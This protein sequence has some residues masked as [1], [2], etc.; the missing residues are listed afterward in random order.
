MRITK[1]VFTDLG[2]WMV[3]FGLMIGIVFP[4]FVTILGV[5]SS[6]A[7]KPGFFAASL[8]AGALAGV[9]N[10]LL[11]RFIVATRIK[12]LSSGMRQVEEHLQDLNNQGNLD[13]CTYESCSLPVDSEDELGDSA[14]AFNR[15][16]ETLAYSLETQEALQTFSEMLASTLELETLAEKSLEMFLDHTGS[17]GGLVL[18]E[19]AGQLEVAASRGIKDPE[20]ISESDYVKIAFQK[21]E[22]QKVQ[23]PNEIKIEGV[24]AEFRPREI[25][26]FPAKYKEVPLGVVVLGKTEA[27][28]A[29]EQIRLELFRQGFGLALNNVLAHDRLQRLAALDPLTGVYNRRFGLRRLHE[30]FERAVRSSSHLGLL[31]M[32][33]DHFKNVNDVYGHQMGDRL[34]KSSATII[35][36]VLREGDVLIRYGGEEFL[37]VLPAASNDDLM[38]IGERMRRGIEASALMDGEQ[39][40]RV[41]ISVGGAAYPNQN[42][43]KKDA[44][45]QLADE[46]LYKAKQTGR[47]QVIISE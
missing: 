29:G 1:K 39:T 31:M 33:L 44:L 21:G 35:R 28:T 46:S 5:P 19:S 27:Y 14:R 4:W 40:V 18:C 42:V 25:I 7:F 37:A 38:L 13:N 24:L 11:A 41:T 47:N 36:S 23:L 17:D 22:I 32:D 30:E 16:V 3:V 34:L 45:L 10:F 2:I 9:L 6:I 20:M 8:G 26:V 43:E 15:L 12:L